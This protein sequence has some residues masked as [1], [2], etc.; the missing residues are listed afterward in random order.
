MYLGHLIFFACLALLLSE[1]VWVVLA[2]H[3]LSRRRRA[4]GDEEHLLQL[5]SAPYR[6]LSGPRQTLDSGNLV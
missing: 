2:A 1:S 5:F 3:V 4:R 6:Y